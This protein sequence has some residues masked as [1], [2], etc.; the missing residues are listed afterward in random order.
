MVIDLLDFTCMIED[1]EQVSGRG[2]EQTANQLARLAL[3]VL[4]PDSS[5][6]A[7]FRRALTF[8][9]AQTTRIDHGKCDYC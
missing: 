8:E 5:A 1:K 4:Q 7:A 9:R 2:G 3:F 6:V